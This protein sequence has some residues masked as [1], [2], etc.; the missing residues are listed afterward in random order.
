MT[1]KLIDDPLT[2]R[3]P[4][5]AVKVWNICLEH[6]REMDELYGLAATRAFERGQGD[7]VLRHIDRH[8][9]DAVAQV[10]ERMVDVLIH[11]KIEFVS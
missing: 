1:L 10:I 11:H 4:P 7:A 3:L 9:Q 2:S 8:H 6:L 5:D